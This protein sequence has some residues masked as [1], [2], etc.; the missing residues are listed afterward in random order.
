M[1]KKK[2]SRA[3]QESNDHDEFGQNFISRADKFQCS[4]KE[5]AT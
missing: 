1:K 2:I 4:V 5:N 3:I